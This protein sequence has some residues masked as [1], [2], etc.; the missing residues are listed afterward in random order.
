MEIYRKKTH[1]TQIAISL[2][3]TENTK[4]PKQEQEDQDDEDDGGKPNETIKHCV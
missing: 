1:K 4:T 3:I 2:Y